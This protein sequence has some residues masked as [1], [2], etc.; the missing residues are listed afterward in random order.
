MASSARKILVLHG[1]SQNAYLL[2]DWFAPVQA[3]CTEDDIEF[4]FVD[5]PFALTQEEIPSGLTPTPDLPFIVEA[6]K[7]LDDPALVPRAWCRSY[8]DINDTTGLEISIEKFRDILRNNHYEGV[9]GFSQG[10]YMAV[11]LTALLEN[12]DVYP[13]FLVDGK[14]PHPPFKFCVAISGFLP[15]SPLFP[16][17]FSTPL[18]TPTLHIQGRSDG[19]TS[20]EAKQT[21]VDVPSTN[22]K[23]LTH[24]GGHVIPIEHGWLGLFRDFF[25]N[26]GADLVLPDDAALG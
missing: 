16:A 24:Q 15:K 20:K 25:R 8:P 21:L 6:P 2:K 9:L 12:P 1:Y 17:L 7:S 4:V 26:P 10:S 14:A 13:P 22:R 11:I 23:Y 18:D 19:I 3:A 5:G